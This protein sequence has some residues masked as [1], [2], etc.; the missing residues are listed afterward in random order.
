MTTFSATTSA[1]ATVLA[2]QQ[3]IWD[4]LTDPDLMARLT[5]YVKRIEADRD[6]WRWEL[7]GLDLLG[8]SIAPSFTERMIFKE[9]DRIEFQHDPSVKGELAGVN[10]WYDLRP[11]DDGEGTVLM[12]ELSICLEAPLPKMAAPAVRRVMRTVL[13]SMGAGFSANLLE[14]LGTTQR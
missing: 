7:S 14:H 8:R 4:C 12:T 6:H 9:P 13:D 10:G 3:D 2:S 11:V 1:E 5:R